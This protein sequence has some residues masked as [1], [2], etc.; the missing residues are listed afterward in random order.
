MTRSARMASSAQRWVESHV[1]RSCNCILY[2]ANDCL[3]FVDKV[4]CLRA[5][6]RV[7]LIGLVRVYR[8]AHDTGVHSLVD[9]GPSSDVLC[10][11]ELR[12]TR[13]AASRLRHAYTRPSPRPTKTTTV[14]MSERRQSGGRRLS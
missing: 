7:Q 10:R 4:H 12:G 2:K 3:S 5:E 13:S 14:Y 11:K 8:R 6:P 1:G 9:E